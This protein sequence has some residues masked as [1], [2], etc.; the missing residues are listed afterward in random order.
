MSPPAPDVTELQQHL[1]ERGL[2]A[3]GARLAVLRCLRAA[4]GPLSHAEAFERVGD[5]GY[6]R[7]TVY[8]NLMDLTEAG[9][10]RRYDLGDHVWRFEAAE[11]GGAHADAP[12]PHFVCNECG[13]IECLPDGSVA[14]RPVRGAPRALRHRGV[15]V[16]LRGLCDAC[17]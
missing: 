13:T 12:H 5:A 3:T 10:A 4:E 16:H 2:R 17:L 8:R 1:R 6:D 11:D 7:A 15:E 9:L 14:L